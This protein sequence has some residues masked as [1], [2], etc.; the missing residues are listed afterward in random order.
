MSL[1]FF[2]S[3]GETTPDDELQAW[4]AYSSPWQIPYLTANATI[5]EYDLQEILWNVRVPTYTAATTTQQYSIFK[6]MIFRV[7]R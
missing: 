5:D 3:Q 4:F 1:L 7:S 2:G 6:P